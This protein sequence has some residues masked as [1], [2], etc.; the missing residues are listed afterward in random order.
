MVVGGW[1][2]EDVGCRIQ[3]EEWWRASVRPKEHG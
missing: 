2:M 3:E 1:W